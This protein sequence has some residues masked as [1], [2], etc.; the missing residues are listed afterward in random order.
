MCRSRPHP[1]SPRTTDCDEDDDDDDSEPLLG[2]WFEE[3]LF[4]AEEKSVAQ[5][6]VDD[7][8]E[9]EHEEDGEGDLSTSGNIVPEKGEP[10][11]FISLASHIFIFL[12]KHLLSSE[13]RYVRAYLMAKVSEQQVT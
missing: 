13:S 7:S 10:A 6:E 9:K 3:T 5:K 12:N 2:R 1:N 11:G 8:E 4:P